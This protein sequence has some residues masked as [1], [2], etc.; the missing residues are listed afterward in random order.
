[1]RDTA[2]QLLMDFI[3]SSYARLAERISDPEALAFAQ[4]RL[5]RLRRSA[6]PFVARR[7]VRT[8][9]VGVCCATDLASAGA[10]AFHQDV[11]RKISYRPA[12]IS[13][14]IGPAAAPCRSR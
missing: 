10:A 1:M 8:G 14:L 7:R 2:S 4:G 5:R 12:H 13:V 9:G 6:P 11:A 3:G